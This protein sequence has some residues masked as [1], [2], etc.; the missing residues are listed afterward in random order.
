MGRSDQDLWNA[1]FRLT[2]AAQL[3]STLFATLPPNN[4]NNM[5]S[6]T[7]PAPMVDSHELSGTGAELAARTLKACGVSRVFA[8]CG[9]H[10]NSLFHAIAGQG[11]E[12]IGARHESAAVQMADGWARATGMPGIAIVT[13]GPGHTNAITGAAVAQ[14]AQSPVVIISGQAPKSRRERGGNQ[15]LHQANLMQPVT[16]WAIEAEDA[17]S[18]GELITRA[19]LVSTSGAPGPVSVS[20]PIDVADAK[21]SKSIKAPT[22]DPLPGVSGED[23]H[24]QECVNGATISRATR[25]LADSKRPVL[26]LGGNAWTHAPTAEL[27]KIVQSLGIPTFTNGHARGVIPDDG[28]VCFGFANPLFNATFK[29]VASADLFLMVGTSA[30]YSLGAVMA[31]D[32]RL[33]QINRDAAQLGIGRIPD[34]ALVG[35]HTFTLG[36]IAEAL[37]KTGDAASRWEDWRRHCRLGYRQ[38]QAYWDD[39]IRNPSPETIGVHP[40]RLCA[41]LGKYWRNDTTIVVDVGDFSNWPKAY[42]P[43]HHRGLYMD[44]GALGNLGGALPISIGVQIARPD[45]PVWAFIGD[46]G[47]G[48]HGW[49]LSV[50][51][52]R[53]LP[54]KVVVGNDHAWGTERRLQRASFRKDIACELPNIRYDQFAELLGARGFMVTSAQALDETIADFIACTGPC[55]LNVALPQLVGRPFAHSA[56]K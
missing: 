46:G 27:G 10:V 23:R 24:A 25:L 31:S 44:G 5:P 29:E 14:G 37:S 43:V 35:G 32:V 34:F 3:I 9:D 38:Q 12:I 2:P 6:H 55:L 41:K 48:F 54:L 39:L 36:Q 33:I 42:F 53:N 17:A 7:A 49:E 8:L 47:F 4:M 18:L 20:I 30:D 1:N 56:A 21:L 16:K 45:R 28:E 22:L 13:G 51:V 19:C 11:I 52:E 50:A 15:S 26:I 40:A